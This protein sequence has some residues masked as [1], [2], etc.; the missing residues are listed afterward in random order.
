MFDRPCHVGPA[1]LYIY[2]RSWYDLGLLQS[3]N[4]HS[5][6][7]IIKALDLRHIKRMDKNVHKINE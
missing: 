7:M 2:Q 6:E 3:S 1:T 5:T 4:F